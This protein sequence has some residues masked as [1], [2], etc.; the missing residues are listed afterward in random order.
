MEWQDSPPRT[1]ERWAPHAPALAACAAVC[2]YLVISLVYA[3]GTPPGS[4]PDEPEHMRYID[5]IAQSGRL[6]LL[7]AVVTPGTRR[8][9]AEQ[10]QHPPLYYLALAGPRALTAALLPKRFSALALRLISIAIALGAL[11]VIWGAARSVWPGNPWRASF[12]VSFVALLPETQYMSAHVSNS[13]GAMLMASLGVLACHRLATRQ[14]AGRRDWFWAALA[15][16]GALCTKMTTLWVL[17]LVLICGVYRTRTQ[18]GPPR[19]KVVNWLVLLAALAVLVGPWLARNQVLYGTPLPERVT[20]RRFGEAKLSTFI[21]LPGYTWLVAR[22]AGPEVLMSFVFPYWLFRERYPRPVA[23]PAMVPFYL[24]AAIGALVCI[25]HGL[26]QR[27]EQ[28]P[29]VQ[30]AYSVGLVAAVVVQVCLV[31]Y[32]SARDYLVMGFAGRY[33]WEAVSAVVLLWTPAVS[34]FAWRPMRMA[35]IGLT[36]A[37]L[38]AFSVWVCQYVLALQ[39]AA[40]PS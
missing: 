10:A 29:R 21:V 20:D 6:P 14:D 19:E 17:V 37:G 9:Q 30:R 28:A 1:T 3:L 15:T 25:W 2:F 36:L 31:F 5:V 34:G 23:V 18:G 35:A 22:M 11:R 16:A 39:A 24:V 27:A 7:P 8:L 13:V 33:A 4:G 12:A 40:L 38:A 26:R 32:M